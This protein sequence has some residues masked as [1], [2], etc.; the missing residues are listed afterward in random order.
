MTVQQG[1]DHPANVG[2]YNSLNLMFLQINS[3]IILQRLLQRRGITSTAAFADDEFVHRV[4]D[5]LDDRRPHLQFPH[6][7]AV[8]FVLLEFDC[9]QA[10]A[11][12]KGSVDAKSALI[13]RAAAI[14]EALWVVALDPLLLPNTEIMSKESGDKLV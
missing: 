12:D 14:V 4:S 6:K 9:A 2:T 5:G 1:S 8:A 11:A 7:A 13:A 10:Y 3:G